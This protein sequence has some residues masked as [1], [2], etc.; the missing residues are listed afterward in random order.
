[1]ML[2]ASEHPLVNPSPSRCTVAGP[3]A[4]VGPSAPIP[5]APMLHF[6][7]INHVIRSTRKASLETEASDVWYHVLYLKDT[8]Q[9]VVAPTTQERLRCRPDTQIYLHVAC[10][11]CMQVP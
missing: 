4:P 7:S 3:S 10:R 5:S 11:F 6:G 1:M 9:P 8:A 2:S